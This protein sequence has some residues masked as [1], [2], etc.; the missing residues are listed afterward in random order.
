MPVVMWS[1]FFIEHQMSVKE[2]CSV[3]Q[4]EE[5]L[6]GEVMRLRN[7]KRNLRWT[8]ICGTTCERGVMSLEV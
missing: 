7:L 5:Q 1:S 3:V 2:C 8:E 6:S 4:V